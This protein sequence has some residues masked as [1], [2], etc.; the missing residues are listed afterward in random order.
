MTT[1]ILACEI[2]RKELEKI[3]DEAQVCCPVVWVESGLHDYPKKLHQ[4]L[5]NRIN[6]IDS[7]R[8]ILTYGLCG[9]SV[10]GIDSGTHELIMPKVDD[11]I[12]M[13][14]GSHKRRKE[15][16]AEL[17]A[18]YLTEGWITGA[19]TPLSEYQ[20]CI[21]KYGQKMAEQIMDMMYHN[22]RSLCLLDTGVVEMDSFS[23]RCDEIARVSCTKK[24]VVKGTLEWLKQLI[25]GPWDD[26]N[27]FTI[28]KPGNKIS[29]NDVVA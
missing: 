15:L 22:Y 25:T 1:T 17:A 3:M 10:I 27:M 14:L 24:C 28:I 18:F 12:T 29:L 4:E 6:Q 11:C 21:E 9:E 2:L 5:V 26:K 8:I 19:K 20:H 7:E 23:T 13:L 16:N